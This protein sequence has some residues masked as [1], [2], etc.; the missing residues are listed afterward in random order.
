MNVD[1]TNFFTYKDEKLFKIKKVKKYP[2]SWNV[3]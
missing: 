2:K 1:A 3:Y